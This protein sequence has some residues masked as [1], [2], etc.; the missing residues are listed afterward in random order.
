MTWWEVEQIALYISDLEERVSAW[1]LSGSQMRREQIKLGQLTQKFQRALPQ[2]QDQK[3]KSLLIEM[4][5]HTKELVDQL[6]ERLKRPLS[7]NGPLRNP[8]P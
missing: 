6:E 3:K 1:S 7:N 4:K 5:K 8:L 2:L